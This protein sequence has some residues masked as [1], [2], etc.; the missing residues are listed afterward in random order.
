MSPSPC[1]LMHMLERRL[2]EK[3]EQLT[4]SCLHCV[5]FEDNR[6]RVRDEIVVSLVRATHTLSL[7]TPKYLEDKQWS[8][9]LPTPRT[10]LSLSW[11]WF[12]FLVCFVTT[13]ACWIGWGHRDVTA[14]ISWFHE[15]LGSSSTSAPRW[16]RFYDSH[17]WSSGASDFLSGANVGAVLLLCFWHDEGMRE[18]R[19]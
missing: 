3:H 6:R 5:S 13:V 8:V 14:G 15:R 2:A 12:H 10:H 4:A 1:R 16:V 11:W 19:K 18:Y 7:L 9:Q 17:D